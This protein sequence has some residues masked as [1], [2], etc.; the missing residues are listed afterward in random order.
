[1]GTR[2]R[3][4]CAQFSR[5]SVPASIQIHILTQGG[6]QCRL[7]CCV[8]ENFHQVYSLVKIFCP[9]I[10]SCICIEDVATFAIVV[11]MNSTNFSASTKVAV[12]GKFLSYENFQPYGSDLCLSAHRCL[13]GRLGY[14]HVYRLKYIYL[15]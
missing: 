1:M 12:L 8:A 6:R 14:F 3:H 11:K 15:L 5:V 2:G 13:S 9:L 7:K 4:P 10:F